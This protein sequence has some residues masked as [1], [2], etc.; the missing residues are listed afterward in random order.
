MPSLSGEDL[1][2][3]TCWHSAALPH[4]LAAAQHFVF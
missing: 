3:D 2:T 4:S 1:R